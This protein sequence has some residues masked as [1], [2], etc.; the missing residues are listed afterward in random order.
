MIC[1]SDVQQLIHD[2]T[3][4]LGNPAQPSPYKDA[5]SECIYEL[6][7]LINRSIQEELDYQDYLE[8]QAN[9]CSSNL[10]SEDYAAA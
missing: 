8:Q 5:L 9:E 6:N 3:E 2:W 4:R 10:K 1:V 7:N